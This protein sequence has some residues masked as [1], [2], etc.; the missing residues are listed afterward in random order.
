MFYDS[1]QGATTPFIPPLPSPESVAHAPPIPPPSEGPPTGWAAQMR[2]PAHYPYYSP[3]PYNTTPFIP[4]LPSGHPTPAMRPEPPGSYFPAPTG[5]PNVYGP[6]QGFSSDYTGYPNANVTP[7]PQAP[8]IPQTPWAGHGHPGTGYNA[9]HQPLPGGH[10]GGPPRGW[11]PPVG[12][13]TPAAAAWGLPPTMPPVGLQT[14]GYPYAQWQHPTAPPP[15]PPAPPG[16]TARADFRWTSNHDRMGPFV[17]GPHYGPVLEPFLAKVVGAHI[18]VNPLLSPPSESADDYL[19]WNM[20]FNTNNCYRTTDRQ[21][22]WMKGR[23]EPATHPRLST[24]R[25]IS[26]VFPWMITVRARDK[27]IGVTCGEVLDGI[28][29]YLQGEVGKKEYEHV[30]SARKR[31]IFSAYSRN[32]STEPG[33]PG[34]HLGE[35]LKRLDF[36]GQNS[37]FGGIVQNDDFVRMQCGDAL[38]CTFELK[39]LHNY[40]PTPRELE[41]QRARQRNAEERARTRNEVED[42]RTLARLRARSRS[43]GNTDGIGIDDD[44]IEGGLPDGYPR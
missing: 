15:A 12:Y 26:T 37:R 29:M 28:A 13:P 16:D 30:S 17:E 7:W 4:P 19:R 10:Q 32:R 18:R 35:A 23:N 21:R 42:E 20:I 3:V 41:D 8:P 33:V 40:P 11:G 22:S 43:P 5:L 36:L 27:K 34:G 44:D 14:P 24:L 25:V 31:E 39:C 9:F 6:P 38:P 2:T 1:P